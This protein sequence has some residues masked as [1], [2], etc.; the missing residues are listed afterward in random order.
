M[1]QDLFIQIMEISSHRSFGAMVLERAFVFSKITSVI[2]HVKS[3]SSLP[4]LSPLSQSPL[5]SALT[6]LAFVPSGLFNLVSFML[7]WLS[8]FAPFKVP[9]PLYLSFACFEV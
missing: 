8:L 7:L 4:T 2:H 1:R 6:L 9:G 5:A 3:F